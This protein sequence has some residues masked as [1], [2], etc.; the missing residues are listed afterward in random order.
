[1]KNK[2][3]IDSNCKLVKNKHKRITSIMH[4]WESTHADF[5]KNEK[6][7]ELI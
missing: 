5:L 4:R 3:G 1:M 2:E 6:S 7:E